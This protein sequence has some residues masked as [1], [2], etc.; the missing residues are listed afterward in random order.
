MVLKAFPSF[1]A[2]PIS[3]NNIPRYIGFLEYLNIPEVT[4]VLAISGLSGLVVVFFLK[5]WNKA[6]SITKHPIPNIPYINA[7][8]PKKSNF[9]TGKVLA[10]I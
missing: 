7:S 8:R 1:S 4:N 6:I 10:K 5:N 2:K 9:P 3:N